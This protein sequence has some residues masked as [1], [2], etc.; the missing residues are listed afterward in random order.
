M[1]IFGISFFSIA[2]L[3]VIILSTGCEQATQ[4]SKLYVKFRI[5]ADGA[6]LGIN[7]DYYTPDG[8][9]IQY[10]LV[11][12]YLSRFSLIK[13]NGEKITYADQ[14]YIA[15]ATEPNLFLIDG[16]LNGKF[17]GVEFGLGV[18]SSR[19]DST[20]SLAVPAYDYPAD[21]ALS[22]AGQLYWDWNPGYIFMKLEGRSDTNSNNILN[23]LGETFSIH[24]GFKEAYRYVVRDYNFQTNGNDIILTIDADINK[25]FTNY[26]IKGKAKDAHPSNAQ[27][28]EFPYVLTIVNNA[29]LVFGEIYE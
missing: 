14:Y 1:K 28:D 19:N 5:T 17:K 10:S 27:H 4:Q 7:Q 8:T 22:A 13:E 6:P 15:D 12:F 23:E 2:L 3:S 11:R 24:T 29:E 18:D 21:H 20:G 16:E 26:N 25:F 9:L